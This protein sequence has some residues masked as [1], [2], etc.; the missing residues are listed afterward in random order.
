VIGANRTDALSNPKI[1]D[2]KL[3]LL[4]PGVGAQGVALKQAILQTHG[5]EQDVL[6]PIS[7]AIC[8]GGNLKPVE[9]QEKFESAQADLESLLNNPRSLS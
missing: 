5:F 1:R 2:S 4:M 6:L 3:P 7:R 9:M 8:E